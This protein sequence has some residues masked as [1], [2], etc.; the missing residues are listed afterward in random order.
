MIRRSLGREEAR[1]VRRT[2]GVSWKLRIVY[3]KEART[4]GSGSKASRDVQS[5]NMAQSWTHEHHWMIV[6]ALLYAVSPQTQGTSIAERCNA[7]HEQ[8]RQVIKRRHAYLY[9]SKDDQESRPGTINSRVQ[10]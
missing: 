10:Y 6:S 7:R 1:Y 3:H 2:N 9:Y 5:L 4:R 8:V